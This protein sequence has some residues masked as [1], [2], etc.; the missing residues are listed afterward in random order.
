MRRKRPVAQIGGVVVFG[1]TSFRDAVLPSCGPPEKETDEQGEESSAGAKIRCSTCADSPL[2]PK[3]PCVITHHH[4][5]DRE[6]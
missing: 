4:A 2:D 3:C 5:A 6:T 1:R